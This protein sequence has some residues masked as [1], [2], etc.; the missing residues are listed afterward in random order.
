L[1]TK[2]FGYVFLAVTAATLWVMSSEFMRAQT[3]SPRP[4]GTP[5]QIKAP[6]GLP[7]VPIPADNPPTKETIALGRRLYYDPL[8]SLDRSVSCATCHGPAG[9]FTDNKSVS[10]GVNGKTGSRSSPTV[11]NSAYSTLQFWDGRA[12]TLEAQAAG[13]MANPVE[14]AHTLDGEVKALQA[15]PTYRAAFKQAWG[16]DQIT[17]DM[18]TKS[19]ASFERTVLSGGSPFDRYYYGRDKKAM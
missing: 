2:S 11:I 12:A 6:L 15:D 13:P 14:M 4:I 9:G 19:I 10:I 18:V 16:T 3:S 17:I 1:N 8:L 5:I 7:P